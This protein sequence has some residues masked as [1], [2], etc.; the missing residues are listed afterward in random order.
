MR[1]EAEA[2]FGLSVQK[3]VCLD[4]RYKSM[5]LDAITRSTS[6]V[7]KLDDSPDRILPTRDSGFN[8]EFYSSW[9]EHPMD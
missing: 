8:E 6:T 9:E 4:R 7:L 1:R 5:D 2:F 3:E